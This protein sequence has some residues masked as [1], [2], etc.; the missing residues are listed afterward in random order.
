MGT[1]IE[2][3]QV[4]RDLALERAECDHGVHIGP[5][6]F[7]R[8]ATALQGLIEPVQALREAFEAKRW[9]LVERLLDLVEGAA[10]ASIADNQE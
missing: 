10:G 7:L 1:R 8:Y 3:A 4:V 6:E 5:R 2:Q 9:S